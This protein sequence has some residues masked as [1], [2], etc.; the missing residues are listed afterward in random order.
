MWWRKAQIWGVVLILSFTTGCGFHPLYG[1]KG[2]LYD[3]QNRDR[4]AQVH[5]SPINDRD[6]LT[7]HNAL[8]ERMRSDTVAVEPRYRL[9]I[10]ISE[11][12]VGINYQKNATASGAEITLTTN[13]Q[14][15]DYQ[16][17]KRLAYG[18]FNS[19]DSVNYLGP[20]YASVAAEQSAKTQSIYD[21]ADM[22]TDR[23]AVYLSEHP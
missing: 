12:T 10:S 20:R 13:W 2:G 22:I 17:G 3:S 5:I 1:K 8:E 18:S 4:F 6:G 19:K 16:S 23:I 15:L 7:L 11:N 9:Q 21:I 14:L